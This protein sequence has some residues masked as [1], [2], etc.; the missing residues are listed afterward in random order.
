MLTAVDV[1]EQLQAAI[2]AGSPLGLNHDPDSGPVNFTLGRM[3]DLDDLS[4]LLG[5]EIVCTMYEEGGTL[6]RTGRRHRQERAFR[7]L[8]KAEH[9]QASIN[10][11]WRLLQWLENQKR[12]ATSSF[13]AWVARFDKLPTVIA[14][15]QSGTALADFVTTFYVWNRTG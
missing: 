1:A 10:L 13:V 12:I 2:S 8:M 9:G 4:S 11:G 3:L 15:D 6:V 14:A 7:F 5:S